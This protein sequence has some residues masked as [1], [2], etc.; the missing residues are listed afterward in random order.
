MFR[1]AGRRND[2]SEGN[3]S[4]SV[5][6]T[7]AGLPSPETITAWQARFAGLP[8]RSPRMAAAGCHS[9]RRLVEARGVEPR[10]WEDIAEASTCLV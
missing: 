10:S 2:T 9:G 1:N 6:R 7:T 3:M 8:S 4:A 5:L